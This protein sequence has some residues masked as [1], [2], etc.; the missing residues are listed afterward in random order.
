[1]TA[2]RWIGVAL[3]YPLL[4]IA[5]VF[6]FVTCGIDRLLAVSLVFPRDPKALARRQ[7]WLV[8]RLRKAGLVP[9]AADV[10]RVVVTP[11]REREAF[12]SQLADV[13]VDYALEGVAG[14]VACIAKFAPRG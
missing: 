1:M 10:T 12:R 13:T 2:L 4:A 8:A 5:F 9:A 14:S 7:A 6:F 3:Y 11:F